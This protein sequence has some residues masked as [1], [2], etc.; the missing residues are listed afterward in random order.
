VGARFFAPVQT[1]P[2][3]YPASYTMGTGSFPGVNRP[4][5]RADHPPPTGAEV[6]ERVELY[7]YSPSGPSWH[8]LGKSLPLPYCL[9]FIVSRVSTR[10]LTCSGWCHV[11]GRN[12]NSRHA[13]DAVT[14]HKEQGSSTWGTGLFNTRNK[15][16]QC[17]EYI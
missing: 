6:K 10:C 9:L 17:Q 11:A 13:R 3:A 4:G 14:G 8:V 15:A 7:L 12:K 2:G 16:P 1:G 5:R